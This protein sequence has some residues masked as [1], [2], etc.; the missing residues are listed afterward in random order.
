MLSATAGTRASLATKLAA[1]AVLVVLPFVLRA[2]PIEHG[3]PR[4]YVPDT[5]MVRA[6][7]GIAKD[8]D[9][10]PPV[11]KYSG[12]PLLLPYL[13][14]P[15]Y[16]AQYELGKWRGEWSDARGYGDHVLEHP[17]DAQRIGRWLV[18]LFGA[19][20]PWAV[21]RAARAA[22]IGRGAWVSAWLVATGLLHVQFSVQERPWVPIMFFFVLAAWFATEYV[23]EARTRWLVLSSVAIGLASACHQGGLPGV[24]IPLA[25]WF[26]A[27]RD[28]QGR[29]T[30]GVKPLALSLG[31]LA[32]V[33]L[34][35]GHLYFLKHGW[36]KPEDSIGG[37]I[38]QA[39]GGLT[40]GGLSLALGS[41]QDS[42]NSF[43]RL[44]RAFFGY[45]PAALLLGAAGFLMAWRVRGLRPLLVFTIVWTAFFMTQQSDHV[46]Y[47]LPTAVFLAWPAGMLAE[48][49][50]DQR[51]S[52][53][54]LAAVL[55][56]P[57]VQVLR[58][59]WL[60]TRTDTRALG[61]VLLAQLPADAVIAI[62]RYGPEADLNERALVRLAELRSRGAKAGASTSLDTLRARERHRY[63]RLHAG[64]VPESQRGVDVV[65]VEELFTFDSRLKLQATSLE[66]R[67]EVSELGATPGD[68]LR[69]LGATHLALVTRRPGVEP[70]L[71]A[72]LVA[73]ETPLWRVD[74]SASATFPTRECFLPTEMDFPLE[75][76]WT[77]SRPGPLIELY[78]LR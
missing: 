46:R 68:V 37:D 24:L 38:A 39:K 4:N 27:P 35:C 5:H 34:V 41:L 62:D 49:W 73:G 22:G 63:E 6:A 9:P 31:F 59:D 15:A 50:M 17:E 12:Y 33:A 40:V 42:V 18:L 20:T 19:L 52:R 25:A 61:E 70:S 66:L 1:L 75:G 13:L 48:R 8:R 26:Y 58:F 57:L 60:L 55:V 3:M 28:A 16:A 56:F 72:P 64:A 76:L 45:D 30:A 36:T 10:I 77:V 47:L 67:P 78:D 54:A 23:K 65:D 21:F 7:L 2:W 44:S 71:L 51:A 74:P 32:L 43:T 14:V 53:I 69:A 11:W 29:R